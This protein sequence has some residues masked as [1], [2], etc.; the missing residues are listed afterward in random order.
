MS[1]YQT[2]EIH[3]NRF[4]L[5]KKFVKTKSCTVDVACKVLNDKEIYINWK[6]KTTYYDITAI[7]VCDLGL[8]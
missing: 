7:W 8:G 6:I 3:Q 1:F 4:H 2:F 5:R